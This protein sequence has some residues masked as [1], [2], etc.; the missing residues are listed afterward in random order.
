MLKSVENVL[1]LRI[2]R[3]VNPTIEPMGGSTTE[4]NLGRKWGEK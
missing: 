3:E 1:K 2:E 4:V